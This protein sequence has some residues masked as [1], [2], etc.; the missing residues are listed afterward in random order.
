MLTESLQGLAIQPQG[1]YVD[2]TFGGGGHSQAILAHLKGGRLLAF[3]QDQEAAQV[4][5]QLKDPAFT[6]IQANARFMDRFLAFHG[7]TQV[8]G[9]LADLGVSSYQIDTPERGFSTRTN[10]FL[11][12][13]MD[14]SAKLTAQELINNCSLESLTDLLQAYGEVR[15]ARKLA[16]AILNFRAKQPIQT[17]GELKA[18]VEPFAPPN[19]IAKLLAQV[20]QAFRIVVNDEI[21]AL[22]AILAQSQQV[23]KPGG[24]LVVL[25]YHSLEDRLVKR[26]IKTGNFEG[27]S[28]KDVYGNLIRPF[29]PLSSKPI[30]PTQEEVTINPRAR[31]AKLRIGER[32]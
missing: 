32:L 31:S 8:D 7:V 13:R 10:G 30:T 9:I 24:R 27:E 25:S 23:L 19:K 21:G 6:F 11:D 16:R 3:D 22:Q 17:T 12:M 14:R 4:A 26:F 2:L 28:Q 5:S 15:P 1:I 18:I 29:K 20:F